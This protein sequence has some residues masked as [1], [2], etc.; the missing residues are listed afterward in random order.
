MEHQHGADKI[1]QSSYACSRSTRTQSL[2]LAT[3]VDTSLEEPR[4]MVHI[5]ELIRM[6]E[7]HG[8]NQNDTRGIRRTSI[9]ARRSIVGS[10]LV[11]RAARA[12]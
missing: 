8:E 2:M 5:R 11:A 1:T 9:Q 3:G 10:R 7:T 6:F 12:P 4:K